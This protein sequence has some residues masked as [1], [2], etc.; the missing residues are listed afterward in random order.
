[1]SRLGIPIDH[2]PRHPLGRRPPKG[3][4]PATSRT[5]RC[6]ASETHRR[7]RRSLYHR[8]GA[9]AWCEW[10][11]SH[12]SLHPTRI[13]GPAAQCSLRSSTFPTTDY[14]TEARRTGAIALSRHALS[15]TRPPRAL[16]GRA[17]RCIVPAKY[18]GRSWRHSEIRSS[19]QPQWFALR[20]AGDTAS[21]PIAARANNNRSTGTRLVLTQQISGRQPL[22][23]GSSAT[24]D[25]CVT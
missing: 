17:H 4:S 9:Q 15:R 8:G 3:R 20:F 16:E 6:T 10:T 11:G 24:G 25:E 18:C 14:G 12:Q 1:M 13:D 19:S 23:P 7:S 22:S 5:S 21:M 2:F